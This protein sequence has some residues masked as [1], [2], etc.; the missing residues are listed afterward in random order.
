MAEPI[1]LQEILK[2]AIQKEIEA[3]AL[4]HTLSE[5]IKD[6]AAKNAFLE[7]AKQEQGHQSLLV[8]YLRGEIKEGALSHGI[9]V[10]YH[11][12]EHLT[13]PEVSPDM[14]LKD[15]FLLAADREKVS[16]DFYLALAGIHPEGKTKKLLQELA[17]QE[18]GHKQ[19]VEYLYTEVAFPQTDG[20]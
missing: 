7:L 20:G 15:V 1:T 9:H 2:G 19:R 3:C 11:I 18:M 4:Y 6:P 17:D 16:H 5:G 10:D 13:Q 12:A 8:K 14:P